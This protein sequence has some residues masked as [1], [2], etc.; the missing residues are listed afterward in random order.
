MAEMSLESE[1][2]VE[3]TEAAG[4]AHLAAAELQVRPHARTNRANQSTPALDWRHDEELFPIY[5]QCS[6]GSRGLAS[7]IPR[8][9]PWPSSVHCKGSRAC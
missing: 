5:S 6:A 7:G 3:P 2:T 1:S 8:M 9:R 4:V